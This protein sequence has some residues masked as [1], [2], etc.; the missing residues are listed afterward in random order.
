[1]TIAAIG[2]LISWAIEAASCPIVVTRLTCAS[3]VCA[4]RNASEAS[5]S[6]L[7]RST[8]RCSSSS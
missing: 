4:S 8:T 1:M 5:I 6:W 3:S 7:V 2:W